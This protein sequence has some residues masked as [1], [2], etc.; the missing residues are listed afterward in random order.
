[1]LPYVAFTIAALVSILSAIKLSTY[2]DLISKQTRFTGFLV[3]TMLLAVATSLPELTTTV[4]AA[5]IGNADIAI[6][7]GLGSILFNLFILFAM[8][9][10]FYKKRIFL[11]G[12]QNQMF[13][14]LLCVVL[15]LV[16]FFSLWF[17]SNVEVLGIG[18]T[19]IIICAT[20]V[21][22]LWLISRKQKGETSSEETQESSEKQAGSLRKIVIRFG[23]FAILI[24]I[25]G[26][27]LSIAGDSIARNT[28]ISS[29][30]IGSFL[31]AAASSFPDA[32]SVFVALKVLNINLAIGTLLGSNLFNILVLCIGDIFF[33]SGSI[34]VA[35]EDKHMLTAGIGVLLTSAVILIVRRKTARTQLWYLAPSFLVITSYVLFVIVIWSLP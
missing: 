7:N 27:V 30:A 33:R 6:G 17:D 22:G 14:G 25:S 1:M 24:L 26:S 18:L 8:D 4:S 20:Y 15:L 34:W 35:A 11:E 31:V 28:G 12:T 19:S 2:A 29:T 23:L 13:P 16:V 21:G 32:V 5:A 3:G 10:I 9:L